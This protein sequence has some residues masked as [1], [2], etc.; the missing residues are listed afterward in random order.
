MFAL[1]VQQMLVVVG[2]PLEGDVLVSRHRIAVDDALDEPLNDVPEIEED[3]KH[4][5]LLLSVDCLVAGSYVT[6]LLVVSYKDKRPYRKGCE[7][8]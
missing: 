1:I 8:L 6:V 7:V 2:L 4:L 5:L 3:D